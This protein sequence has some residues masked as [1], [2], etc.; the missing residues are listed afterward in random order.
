MKCEMWK[1]EEPAREDEF[2]CEQHRQEMRKA[3]TRVAKGLLKALPG[4]VFTETGRASGG[5]RY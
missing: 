4:E 3:K 1:C 5:G 2:L